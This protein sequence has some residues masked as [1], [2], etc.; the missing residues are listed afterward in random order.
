MKVIFRTVHSEIELDLEPFIDIKFIQAYLDSLTIAEEDAVDKYR[1]YN[2]IHTAH[3][4]DL[5]ELTATLQ[6]QVVY[7][8]GIKADSPLFNYLTHDDYVKTKQGLLRVL[9]SRGV[10]TVI[11]NVIFELT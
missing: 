1:I 10:P 6:R 9:R 7:F 2:A 8:E 11:V 4:F 5:P 3:S